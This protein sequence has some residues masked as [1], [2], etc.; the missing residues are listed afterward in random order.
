MESELVCL[1]GEL[2]EQ[3]LAELREQQSVSLK[4]QVLAWLLAMKTEQGWGVVSATQ[5]ALALV[6]GKEQELA[7]L[8]ESASAYLLA[9]WTAQ[10]LVSSKEPA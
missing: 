1:W 5:T 4:E 6:A 2:R 10:E 8:K 9:L 7:E 3:A